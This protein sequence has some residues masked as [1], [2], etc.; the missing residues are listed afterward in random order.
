MSENVKKSVL[1]IEEPESC[2]D[3]ACLGFI[4]Y[5]AYCQATDNGFSNSFKIMLKKNMPV[6]PSW[7]PLRPLPDYRMD[8]TKDAN[9]YGAGFNDCLDLI[10]GARK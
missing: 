9:S 1:V 10:G 4:D 2:V 8:W 3:C 5:E 6:K 7:C